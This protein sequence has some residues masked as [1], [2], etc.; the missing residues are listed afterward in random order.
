MNFMKIAE[1]YFFHDLEDGWYALFI[2]GKKHREYN[3]YNDL[4]ADAET[5]GVCL[6]WGKSYN[7]YDYY[8]PEEL[9]G[10]LC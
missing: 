5:L 6:I 10:K 8:C 4:K 9:K 2:D 1:V 7:N 3:F